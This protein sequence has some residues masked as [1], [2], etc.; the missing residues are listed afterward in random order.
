VST[1]SPYAFAGT[2]TVAAAARRVHEALVDLEHYPEWWPQV[3]AV[4]SLGADDARVLCR[5]VLPYT[6]DLHLHAERRDA[7]LLEVS[8]AG[9]LAGF[10]RWELNPLRSGTELRFTQEVTVG[11]WLAALTPVVRPVLGWNH[12]RM[13][14]GCLTGLR[15]RLSG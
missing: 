1:S 2:W 6:L 10:A 14:D 5:S 8:L 13:M 4:A 9:D 3:V 11:G 7:H 15:R 12:R